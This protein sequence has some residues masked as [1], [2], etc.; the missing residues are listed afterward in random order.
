VS[1]FFNT[2]AFHPKQGTSWHLRKL[3]QGLINGPAYAN[4]DAAVLKDFTL[5]EPYKLQ[6]RAES[7]NT[8]NQVVFSNP[9]SMATST[10]FGPIQSPANT[11]RQLQLALKLLR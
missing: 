2:E 1:Q 3:R 8:F 10:S 9:N 11:G 4:T 7:F 6:F 5:R